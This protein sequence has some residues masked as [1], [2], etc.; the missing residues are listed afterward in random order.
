MLVFTE[1][2]KTL[3]SINA[4]N[5]LRISAEHSK[6]A[7]PASTHAFIGLARLLRQTVGSVVCPSVFLPVTLAHPAKAMH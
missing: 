6:R 4:E 1:S 5:S 2:Q 7:P 3:Y